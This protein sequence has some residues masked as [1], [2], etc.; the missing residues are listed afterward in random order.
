MDPVPDNFRK[1]EV[2]HAF[3]VHVEFVI[4]SQPRY[5]LSHTAF[6]SVAFVDEG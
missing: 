5:P 2:V 6:S 4:A 3:A 1:I